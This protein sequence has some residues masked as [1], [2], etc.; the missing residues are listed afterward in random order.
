ML[1]STP[2]N[3][4]ARWLAD[5]YFGPAQ[6]A[7]AVLIAAAAVAAAWPH[8][9]GHASYPDVV[10][11]YLALHD[12]DKGIDGR[13]SAL[14][15]GVTAAAAVV[16]GRSFRR[17]APDGPASAVGVAL[18]QALLLSL[19]PAAWELTV[20][21]LRR[22]D[23]APPVQGVAVFPLLVLWA[24][25]GLGRFARGSFRPADAR[26]GVGAVVLSVVFAAFAA[27]AVL[28]TVERLA[29]SGRVADVVG[30]LAMP[31]A[32]AGAALAGA[33]VVWAAGGGDV[34]RFRRRVVRGLVL[35]QV[36]LPLLLFALVPPPL[37][38]PTHQFHERY[39]AALVAVLAA[40]VATGA[41]TV[42]RRLRGPGV[43]TLR[44]AVAPAA[45]VALMVFCHAPT[46]AVPAVDGD[47]FHWGEQVL[48]WQQWWDLHRRPYVDFVPVH[49]LMAYARGAFNQAFFDGTAAHYSAADALLCGLALAAA[50][51]GACRL[52]GPMAALVVLLAP[53]P[54]FDRLYLLPAGL[55]L[56]AAPATWRRPAVGLVAWAGLCAVMVGYNAA[57]GPAFVVATAPVAAWAAWRAGWRR[58]LAVAAGAGAIA[59]VAAAV[60]AVRHTAVEFVRFVADNGWTNTTAHDMPWDAGIGQRDRPAGLGSSQFLWETAR[61]GWMAVAVVAAGLA[62]RAVAAVGG[63]RD[64]LRPGLLPLA[65]STALVLVIAFPWTMGRIGPGNLNRPGTTSTTALTYL[66]PA[67]LL[68]AAPARRAAR[69]VVVAAAVIGLVQLPQAPD[70]DATRLLARAGECRRVPPGAAVFDGAKAGLPNVG[71]VVAP[72]PNWLAGVV[73]LRRGLDRLLRPGETYLDL[74]YQQALYFYLGLPVPVRYVAY[75]AANGRLQAAELRQLAEQPVPAVM[76]GPTAW[77]DGLPPSLRCYPLWRA[78]ALRYVPVRIGTFTFLVDPVRAAALNGIPPPPPGVRPAVTEAD[79]QTLDA[80][81]RPDDLQFIPVSWGRSWPTLRGRFDVVGRATVIRQATAADPWAVATVPATVPDGAAADFL[82]LRLTMD[83][84]ADAGDP[85]MRLQWQDVGGAW[86]PTAAQFKGASGDLLVPLGAYPRWLLDRG[87]PAVRVSVYNGSAVRSWHLAAATFLRLKPM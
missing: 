59:A 61:L 43:R 67:L 36:P 41:W 86:P 2:C 65:V 16:I 32:V 29:G 82:L 8:L 11:G 80:Y 69:A 37:V 73:E 85:E 55:Y 31:A 40:C 13:A 45:V 52:L 66:L 84:A 27:T 71:Q 56:A 6:I 23:A 70:L 22:S 39:P 42:A 44:R 68:L 87:V 51:G 28:L 15:A 33:G 74:T 62:W 64:R 24:A 4:A 75:V 38:D 5:A 53:L 18:N 1:T 10:A 35:W 3:R 46:A 21:A 14:L 9:R 30:R 12:A 19:A 48:P 58:S 72:R 63:R 76:V 60:P 47:H 17:V 50:A 54:G 7:A 57:I 25:A 79:L 81:L 78:Y 77:F 26:A 34:R 20:A 83:R 49:G